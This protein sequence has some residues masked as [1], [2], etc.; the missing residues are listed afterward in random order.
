MNVIG[1]VVE[2]KSL[3]EG[4]I[5]DHKIRE[6]ESYIIV[7]F[8]GDQ[9]EFQFPDIFKNIIRAKDEKFKA[10]VADLVQKKEDIDRKEA[11][12]R[13]REIEKEQKNLIRDE[14]IIRKTKVGKRAKKE[15]KKITSTKEK[16]KHNK[17]DK[18]H[19]I[20]FKCN[21][22]DGGKSSEQVGFSGICSNRT[23]AQNIDRGRGEW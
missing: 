1:Q 15:G 19:N 7:D 20:A 10:Y 6:R 4:K 17:S 3:G 8:S 14:P 16:G 5:C 9:K 18:G 11:I 21:Y 13:Q 22:C 23:I 12:I 2:H